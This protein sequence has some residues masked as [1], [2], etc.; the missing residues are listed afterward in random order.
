[1]HAMQCR[2]KALS[3]NRRVFA[4]LEKMGRLILARSRA[5]RGYP[6]RLCLRPLSNREEE[7][8]REIYLR[9]ITR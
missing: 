8:I 2:G 7:D 3:Q 4:S 5:Q 6:R 1:M 9:V